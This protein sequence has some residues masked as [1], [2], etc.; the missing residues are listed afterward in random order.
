MAL[1]VFPRPPHL[2]PEGEVK[3]RLSTT[4]CQRWDMGVEGDVKLTC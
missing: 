4:S 3:L 2:C 1:L